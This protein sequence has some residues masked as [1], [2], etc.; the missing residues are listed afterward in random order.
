M[1]GHVLIE[2]GDGGVLIQVLGNL[3]AAMEGARQ[4]VLP[5]MSGHMLLERGDGLVLVLVLRHV[6]AVGER[7]LQGDHHHRGLGVV[8]DL[9]VVV[10]LSAQ[11]N[12]S[13]FT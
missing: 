11:A 4:G 5:C 3:V 13:D 1:S 2:H 8:V 6:T 12:C 9:L 10:H 7:A